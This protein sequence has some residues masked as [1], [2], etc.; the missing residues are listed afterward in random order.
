MLVA[1]GDEKALK[2]WSPTI[3]RSRFELH[4][5][6]RS[7]HVKYVN[8]LNFEIYALAILKHAWASHIWSFCWAFP[9]WV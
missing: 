2:D 9:Y 8:F 1:A 3:P 7:S 4:H 5:G 6:N